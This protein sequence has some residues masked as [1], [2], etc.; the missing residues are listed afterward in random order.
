MKDI[1]L[2][3]YF[4]FLFISIIF[5]LS[6]KTARAQY[7]QIN[8]NDTLQKQEKEYP[9]IFPVFGGKV[10]EKGAELPLP[11]GIML[12]TFWARQGIVLEKLHVG[13][14][15]EGINVP[16]TDI[17]R[18][19]NFSK[20]EA[21]ALSVNVRPDVWILPFWNVYGIVGKTY[22]STEVRMDYPIDLYTLV[23]T[24]GFTYGFGTTLAFGLGPVFAVLD[25]NL[26][27]TNLENIKKPVRSYVFSF[28]VGHFIKFKKSKKDAGIALWAGAM[29]VRTGGVSDGQIK[30]SEVF[31][32]SKEEIDRLVDEYWAWYDELSPLDPKKVIADKVFNPIIDNISNSAGTGEIL[33]S[34]E[35]RPVKEWNF[36]IGG[37][38][39]IDPR[40]QIRF[41]AGFFGDRTQA[42]LS[43]NYRFG[44][45]KRKR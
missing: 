35:K 26:T 44:I 22:T 3:S 9:Y 39:Q 38:Y 6:G 21:G 1:Y 25:G 32:N 27:W 17:D 13:F 14:Q 34:F 18:I 40:W 4:V 15:S 43:A 23:Y 42:L 11:W 2:R 41:E 30:I 7:N 20:I 10:Y 24:E 19:V 16:L 45:R 8:L 28:R 37:Q 33:Y 36:I 5:F 12:N 29:R 31:P